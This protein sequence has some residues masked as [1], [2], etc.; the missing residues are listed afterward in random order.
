[1][2]FYNNVTRD[3]FEKVKDHVESIIL[4]LGAK[5]CNIKLPY[6]NITTT[7]TGEFEET[8]YSKRPVFSYNS[9]YFRVDENLF[10]QKPFI[11][12]ESGSLEQLMNNI[13][14]DADPFPYDLSDAELR[15]EV[16]YS[17]GIE[18][19]PMQLIFEKSG[20]KI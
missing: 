11:I 3:D 12:I 20:R 7:Y 5:I 15:K 6:E 14:D 1:M 16:K 9:E 10:R 19:Y 17:L 18:P 13:M 8:Y 2:W 4:E